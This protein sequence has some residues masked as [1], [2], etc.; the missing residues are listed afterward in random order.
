MGTST[1]ISILPIECVVSTTAPVE[2]DCLTISH[3]CTRVA[4]SIPELGSSRKLTLGAAT[5]AMAALS[6]RLL[7]NPILCTLELVSQR[8]ATP[9]NLRGVQCCML[10]KG[11]RHA[12]AS[13][14]RF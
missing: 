11:A 5:S 2:S 9:I 8:L 10:R 7:L 6:L 3:M 4:T 13:G 12:H 1:S 14:R